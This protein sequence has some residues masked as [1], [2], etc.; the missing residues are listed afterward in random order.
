M[1]FSD[2][3][4]LSLSR[5]SLVPGFEGFPR[6]FS[7][8]TQFPEY[9]RRDDAL[10]FGFSQLFFYAKVPPEARSSRQGKFQPPGFFSLHSIFFLY[11]PTY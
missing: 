6:F 11:F 8:S 9:P 1:R 3:W 10:G 7:Q 4:V 5:F 2:S